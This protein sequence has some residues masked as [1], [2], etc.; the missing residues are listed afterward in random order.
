MEQRV[1]NILENLKEQ[2]DEEFDRHEKRRDSLI[3]LIAET[4]KLCDHTYPNGKCAVGVDFSSEVSGVQICRVCGNS[5]IL[6]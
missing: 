1:I 3:A 5:L 2:L 6:A 4:N